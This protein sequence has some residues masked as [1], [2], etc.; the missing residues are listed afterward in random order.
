MLTF[1]QFTG[2]RNQNSDWRQTRHF[3]DP[4][5]DSDEVDNPVL[6]FFVSSMDLTPSDGKT[7]KQ[8]C[9]DYIRFWGRAENVSDAEAVP[10][11]EAAAN[12]MRDHGFSNESRRLVTCAERLKI[13]SR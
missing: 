9:D 7:A 11:L 2:G 8:L 13:S 4:R 5:P 3:Y 10:M 1:W 12:V 6:R